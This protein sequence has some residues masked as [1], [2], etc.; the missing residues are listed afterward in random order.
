MYTLDAEDFYELDREGI[1]SAC[2]ALVLVLDNSDI[3]RFS[4]GTIHD[5]FSQTHLEPFPQSDLGLS[6]ACMSYLLLGELQNERIPVFSEHLWS[7]DMRERYPFYD[8][9]VR[10]WATHARN[11]AQGSGRIVR[12][13][14]ESS[15]NA[16]PRAVLT[17]AER[18][19]R[20]N[21]D[22]LLDKVGETPSILHLMNAKHMTFFQ[23][24]CHNGWTTIIENILRAGTPGWNHDAWDE[25]YHRVKAS[26][27]FLDFEPECEDEYQQ[28]VRA[29]EDFRLEILD[30]LL[31]SETLKI[32]A[33]DVHGQ[34]SLHCV[35][36][37]TSSN[38][39]FESPPVS[40]RT[41]QRL[42]AKG[43]V[44]FPSDI[45]RAHAG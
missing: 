15:P 4:H 40:V 23:L 5:I 18:G 34:T 8:C 13:L 25:P 37:H 42:I 29:L 3:V 11:A 7:F 16:P 19:N 36:Y 10:H 44:S 38:S 1:V 39:D 21:V 41:L 33:K 32:Y 35:K 2:T 12:K 27:D 9:A 45:N 17:E 20:Q 22:W 6:I 26:L 14:L 28:T 31:A 43:A 24:A 30:T